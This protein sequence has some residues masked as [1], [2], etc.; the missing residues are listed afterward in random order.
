[1]PVIHC[2]GSSSHTSGSTRIQPRVNRNK[3]HSRHQASSGSGPWSTRILLAY[4]AAYRDP[5]EPTTR[6]YLII[7]IWIPVRCALC[8]SGPQQDPRCVIT[9]L[10]LMDPGVRLTPG[11]SLCTPRGGSH[12]LCFVPLALVWDYGLDR[13]NRLPLEI[14]HPFTSRAAP[15]LHPLVRR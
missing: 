13:K 15:V 4:S 3:K 5:R 10:R 7:L 9:P 1:M 12:A 6:K 11:G 14:G 8:G 2:T